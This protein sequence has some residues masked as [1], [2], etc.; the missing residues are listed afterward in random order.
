MENNKHRFVVVSYK[1]YCNVNGEE[2]LFEETDDMKPME[3][4][5]GCDLS[6]PAFEQEIVK[7]E[8]DA[9]FEFTLAKESSMPRTSIKEPSFLC[10]TKKV[11][12][13]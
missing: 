5:T 13:S 11:N 8:E 2:K 4:Y 9:D 6:L 10:R 7:F 3:L 12:A 1:L